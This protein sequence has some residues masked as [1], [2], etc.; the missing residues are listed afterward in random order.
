ML[1]PIARQWPT[2]ENVRKQPSWNPRLTQV[3]CP[4]DSGS[5]HERGII[6]LTEYCRVFLARRRGAD[7]DTGSNNGDHFAGFDLALEIF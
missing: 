7:G 3:Q 4:L 2:I 6:P 1:E 5:V